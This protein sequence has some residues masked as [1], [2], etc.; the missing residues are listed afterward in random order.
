MAAKLI[1]NQ[2]KVELSKLLTVMLSL[3]Q[4]AEELSLKDFNSKK[5]DLLLINLERLRLIL[6]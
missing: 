5:L 6:T 2:L 3:F 4:L 1:L